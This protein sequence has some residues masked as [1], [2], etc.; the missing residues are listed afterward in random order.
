[1]AEL[2]IAR[3]LAQWGLRRFPDEDAYYAWQRQ[4]LS[5]ERLRL[6]Q[7]TAQTRHDGGGADQAFYDLAASPDV[8]PVLYSQRYGYY[9]ELGPAIVNVLEGAL[10]VLDVG[11]GVGI[12]TTWYAACFPNVT[13][14]GIDRSL[15]SIEVARQFAQSRHLDNVSFR[16]CDIP[17]HEI[18]GTFD[19]IVSTQALFQ[20]ESDPGLPSRSWTT[21][22]RDRDARQQR[23]LEERT[24][25]GPRLD[26]LLQVLESPGRFVL[27][28]KAVH[29]GRRV[30]F[31]R[32]LEARGCVAV[33]EPR[34]L[35][36][37][38]L[39]EPVE[40]GPLYVM[41]RGPAVPAEVLREDVRHDPQQGLYRCQGAHADF[42][43]ARLPKDN[44]HSDKAVATFGDKDGWYET[45]RTVGGLGYVRL[46]I[47]ETDS[48]L[49]VGMVEQQSLMVEL[50]R[51]EWQQGA[52]LTRIRPEQA[53]GPA[54]EAPLYE[55]HFPVAEQVWQQLPDRVVLRQQT[56]EDAERRQRHI[57]YGRCAGNLHYLYW[58]NTFDQRQIVIMEQERST[59]LETYFSE[60]IGEG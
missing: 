7:Q 20:S 2:D 44:A 9:H 17:Q 12:L 25:I 11:C 50:V 60:A 18:P 24:G 22:E 15:Q 3:H 40:E 8:L 13:F 36:Y 53:S 33:A 45:G 48:G 28:E 27:F 56:D 16:H 4:S 31:Q 21:F 52:G 38:E 34:L 35:T 10:R 59:I 26:L 23:E 55:N 1:M 41:A 5:G 46:M 39:G 49:L 47:H 51:H 14:L 58:A 19:T 29:L 37:S 57:E 42:V 43:Y 32:A 6:L 30:L 54:E